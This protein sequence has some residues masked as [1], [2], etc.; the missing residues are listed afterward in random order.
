[1]FIS[2]SEMSFDAK[3]VVLDII[4]RI[5]PHGFFSWHKKFFLQQ[6]KTIL[7]AIR[8]IFLWHETVCC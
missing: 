6:G 5:L 3:K 1:M 8:K 4:K 7:N 2:L